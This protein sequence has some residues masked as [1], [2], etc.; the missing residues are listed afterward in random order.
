MTA[1]ARAAQEHGRPPTDAVAGAAL[2]FSEGEF[3]EGEDVR[4]LVD[5][6]VDGLAHAVAGIGVDTDD[7]WRFAGLAAGRR[8]NLNE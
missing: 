4:P 3:K 5:Q 6:L 7:H 1:A 2:A 8:A